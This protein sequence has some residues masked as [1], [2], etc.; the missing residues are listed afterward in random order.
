[1]SF[2]TAVWTVKDGSLHAV[3]PSRVQRENDLESW[4]EADPGSVL[5]MPLA[6]I[7][8]QVRTASGKR[9]D[10]LALDTEGNTVIIEL[11][12]GMTP[13]EVVAQILDYASWVRHL[14]FD[15]LDAIARQHRG[16]SLD[17]CFKGAFDTGLPSTVNE[18]HQMVI[19]ASRLDDD[20]ERIVDYLK[21][22]GRLSINAVFFN[23]FD[24]DGTP[25]FVRSWLADP[26]EVAEAAAP[27][28]RTPWS[29]YWV[30]NVGDWPRG[31]RPW[32]D[33]VKHG[34]VSAGGGRRWSDQLERLSPGDR[35]FAFLKQRGYVGVGEVT[36][37]MRPISELRDSDSGRP[38]LASL[39]GRSLGDQS[40]P[41][42][43]E[44]AVPVRW[45][46]TVPE[47]DA[48]WQDGLAAT[49]QVTFKL[50]QPK[51]VEFLRNAFGVE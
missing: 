2:K 18:S 38:L 9:I 48:K 25:I 16:A 28:K 47:S 29:G 40:D 19:V 44:Y 33:R 30:V 26:E 51:T 43:A 31:H 42:T 37:P 41:E 3:P 8:R 12:R 24:L 6:L 23:M 17:D 46:R 13:R 36:G 15:D 7:G 39:S 32:T 5:D 20:S 10:L 4:I 11:K 49:P 35:V 34:F 21:T 27:A 1:M 22:E 45:I 14:G 50:K